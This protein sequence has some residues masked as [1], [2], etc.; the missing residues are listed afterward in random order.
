M[1]VNIFIGFV[2]CHG[3]PRPCWHFCSYGSAICS[4]S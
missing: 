4:K 1:V 2:A 3:W